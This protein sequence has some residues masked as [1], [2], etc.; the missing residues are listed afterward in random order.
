[1]EEAITELSEPECVKRWVLGKKEPIRYITIAE[2]SLIPDDD[3]EI[4]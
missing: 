4:A 1:M 3:V 2:I